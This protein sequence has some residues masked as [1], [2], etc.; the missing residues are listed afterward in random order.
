MQR[1][2]QHHTI[3]EIINGC[4][5]QADGNENEERICIM[6]AELRQGLAIV[7]ELSPSVTMYG[8][9]RLK[10]TKYN[11]LAENIAKKVALA[12]IAVITGGGPGIME[13]ANKGASEAGG[14][15][16]GLT[17]VLPEEQTT[18]PYVNKEAPFYYFFTRKLTLS[19]SSQC[20]VGFPGG[21]GTMD[22]ICE[23]IDHMQNNKI[24]RRPLILVGSEFWNPLVEFF[25]TTLLEKFGAIEEHDMN[26]FEV[27]DDEDAIVEKI[28][29]ACLGK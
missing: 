12:K 7:K 27:M 1:R 20:F 10:N 25:R 26:I 14:I 18:N 29:E 21:F 13:D 8:S 4:E 16:A 5:A 24:E 3:D 6:T 15:S 17:I 2:K 11:T 22:E 28:K 19:F 9:S 23:L